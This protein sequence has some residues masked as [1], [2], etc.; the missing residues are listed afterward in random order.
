MG[1]SY[2]LDLCERILSDILS[3]MSCRAVAKKYSVSHFF[4]NKLRHLHLSGRPLSPLRQGGYKK[5]KIALY[6]NDLIE[7]IN[8]HCDVTLNDMSDF[9]GHKGLSITP[10]GVWLYLKKNNI[11]YKKNSYR[12]RKG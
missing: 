10:Q 11:S 4:A 7:F 12:K 6:H 5:S 8:E 1:K 2:S 3:G 9:L